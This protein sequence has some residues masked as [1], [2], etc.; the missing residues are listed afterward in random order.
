MW[1]DRVDFQNNKDGITQKLIDVLK[2]HDF[3]GFLT[4]TSIEGPGNYVC[5]YFTT[6]DIKAACISHDFKVLWNHSC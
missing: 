3:N 5:I 2:E 1:N 4:I 6:G